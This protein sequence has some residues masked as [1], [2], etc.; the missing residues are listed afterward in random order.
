[1]FR[2]NFR[3]RSTARR[4]ARRGKTRMFAAKTGSV[5]RINKTH[6]PFTAFDSTS[7]V[8]PLSWA[9]PLV[10]DGDWTS[11][12][13]V[14]NSGVFLRGARHL[15]TNL[16]FD[17]N[18][19]WE[20]DVEEFNSIAPTSSTVAALEVAVFMTDEA[21]LLGVDGNQPLPGF[22]G[23]WPRRIFERTAQG[24][25]VNE[26]R[27]AYYRL[28]WTNLVSPQFTGIPLSDIA[29]GTTIQ[30]GGQQLL[31]SRR[32]KKTRKLDSARAMGLAFTVGDTGGF[33]VASN[34]SNGITWDKSKDLLIQQE[35]WIWVP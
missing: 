30:W 3:A 18:E 24:W 31:T 23:T 29:N 17:M 4:T 7:V 33:D 2:R 32:I 26:E 22:F 5:L 20:H 11:L 15:A 16:Y 8:S 25:L 9:L 21:E 19:Q 34:H 14:T 6:G 35:T 1:M 10:A 13:E 28:P 12:P 27:V